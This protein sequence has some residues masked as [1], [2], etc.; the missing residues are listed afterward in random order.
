MLGTMLQYAC[1]ECATEGNALAYT[2][3]ELSRFGIR[4]EQW[5]VNL[6]LCELKVWARLISL[7]NF[8]KQVLACERAARRVPTSASVVSEGI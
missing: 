4:K 1:Q 5:L 8:L 6:D 7:C 3:D 2:L